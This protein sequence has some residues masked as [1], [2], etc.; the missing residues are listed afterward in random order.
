[1]FKKG[2]AWKQSQVCSQ[3]TSSTQHGIDVSNVSTLATAPQNERHGRSWLRSRVQNT[4]CCMQLETT[5][6]AGQICSVV[7][8][9]T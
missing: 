4:S 2:V 6:L 3:L 7:Q 1:M 5:V 9:Q 8:Y